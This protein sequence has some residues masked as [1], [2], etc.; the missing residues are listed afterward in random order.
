MIDFH[1]VNPHIIINRTIK[2]T[3]IIR[4][5]TTMLQQDVVTLL[6]VE[7]IIEEGGELLLL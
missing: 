2:K 1:P 6:G 4:S 3:V 7:I 5:G